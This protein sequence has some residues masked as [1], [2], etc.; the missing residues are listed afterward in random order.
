MDVKW[1]DLQGFQNLEGL[2]VYKKDKIKIVV[3][4]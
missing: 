3:F 4:I 1:E 2:A